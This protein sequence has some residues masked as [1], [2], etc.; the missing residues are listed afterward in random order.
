MGGGGVM[1]LAIIDFNF[2]HFGILLIS[3]APPSIH[4]LA[5]RVIL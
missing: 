2:R 4:L 1:L 5:F 3:F